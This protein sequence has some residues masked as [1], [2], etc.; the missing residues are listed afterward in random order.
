[1]RLSGKSITEDKK[2][3]S[4]SFNELDVKRAY[5]QK[6]ELNKKQFLDRYSLKDDKPIFVI[7][8][9]SFKDAN[10]LYGRFLFNDFYDEINFILQKI[11][12]NK[13]FHWFVKPHPMSDHYGEE[14]IVANLLNK[15]NTKN[16]NLVDKDHSTKSILN[17]AD[18][19]FTSRGTIAIEFAGIGKKPYISSTSYYSDL[20]FSHLISSKEEFEK[21]LN[22][23][24]LESNYLREE[25]KT[26]AICCLYIRKEQIKRKNIFNLTDPIRFINYEEF[27]KQLKLNLFNKNKHLEIKRKYL[28]ALKYL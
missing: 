19:I 7:A 22:D 24:K 12:D 21:C 10:H 9:H 1:M 6:K 26:D 25:Q 13:N 27:L 18:K 5:F 28:N 17:I 11:K 20:G 23:N 8:T 16:V 15:L 4:L 14:D 3:E 2:D